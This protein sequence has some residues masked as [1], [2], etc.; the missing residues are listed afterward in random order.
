MLAPCSGK[1]SELTNLHLIAQLD[2]SKYANTRKPVKLTMATYFMANHFVNKIL[3]R[4][5]TT[6]QSA[7]QNGC[8]KMIKMLI[9]Q[10]YSFI[11]HI[12]NE[13]MSKPCV[14]VHCIQAKFAF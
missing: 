5:K 7:W 13:Y 6:C 10:L 12:K 8:I 2:L 3:R 11:F 4:P 1:V 14:T 9:I